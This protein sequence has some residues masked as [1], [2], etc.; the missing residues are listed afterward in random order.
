MSLTSYAEEPRINPLD[1]VERLAAARDAF[2]TAWSGIVSP[3][4]RRFCSARALRSP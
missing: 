4:A 3:A 2:T 1:V